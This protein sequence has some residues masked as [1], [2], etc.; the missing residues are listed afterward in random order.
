[1]RAPIPL[2]LLALVAIACAPRREATVPFPPSDALDRAARILESFDYNVVELDRERGAVRGVRTAEHLS[3]SVLAR[4]SRM[5]TPPGEILWEV[6]VHVTPSG[7]GARYRLDSRSMS[8]VRRLEQ[9][10]QRHL[11]RVLEA[12]ADWRR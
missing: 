9:V 7:D 2:L 11:D 5:P 6:T 1:M 8:G 3:P 4:G 10:D 12:L